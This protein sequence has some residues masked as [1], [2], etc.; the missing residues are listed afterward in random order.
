MSTEAQVQ[1]AAAVLDVHRWKTMGLG[2]VECE[3]GDVLSVDRADT[4]DLIEDFVLTSFPA[5]VAFREHI[6]RAMLAAVEAVE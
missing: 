3:C 4:G 1:A 5:D 6:A 2:T